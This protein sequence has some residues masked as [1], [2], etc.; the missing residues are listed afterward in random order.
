MGKDDTADAEFRNTLS[1]E[2]QLTEEQKRQFMALLPQINELNKR[3]SVI[4]WCI[5]ALSM[6]VPVP[7]CGDL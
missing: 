1:Q 2:L 3:L 6:N 4:S 7:D 5:S